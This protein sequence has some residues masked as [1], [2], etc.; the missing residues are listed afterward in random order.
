MSALS[1]QVPFPVFQDRDGQPLGNGYVWIGE[2]SLN[3]QTNPVNVYFDEALTIAAAQPLRT[4]NGYIYRSGSPAQVYVDGVDFSILVQD[5]K[6]SLVYSLASGTG[7]S[8]NASGI[9]YD[10][11]GTGAVPTTVQAKLREDVSVKD[12]GAVGDGTTD[13]TDAFTAAGSSASKIQVLVPPGAY[14]LNSSPAP[15]GDVTWLL[16]KGV[17]LS[18]SG[19]LPNAIISYGALTNNW[20]KDVASGIFT[21]LEDGSTLNVHGKPEL[22][23]IFAATRSSSG[24]GAS[25]NSNICIAAF[26]LNDK[27]TGAAGV[28][29]LY[30]TV[31]KEEDAPGSTLGMEIDVAHM[32]PT[33]PAFPYNL[34][35][36]GLSVGVWLASGG[37]TSNVGSPGVATAGIVLLQN[38]SQVTPTASFDKGIIFHAKAISGTDGVT[39]NGI[40]IAM[41][42]GHQINWY[43]PS[44]QVG[45]YVRSDTSLASKA[46][47]IAFTDSGFL[48][49]DLTSGLPSLQ[50]G[51]V[52]NQANR[53][54]VNPSA[55]G[56]PVQVNSDGV[57]SDIDLAFFPKG[58]GV[59][60]FGA[61]TS[62]ADAAITG[63]I[64]IKD[65][66][67]NVRKLATIA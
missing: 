43:T 49:N 18:G 36:V 24:D 15:T 1:I 45:A 14:L 25:S 50:I 26:A 7:I 48:V 35:P 27:T 44:D 42:K 52:V 64:T 59:L 21:Y 38:D 57:D 62:N 67:G 30:S 13:D 54:V 41:A 34:F 9:V 53:V 20:V 6:G 22:Q 11:A 33:S 61:F 23:G 31:L 4:L 47:G 37:E 12:F 40:A 56:Q 2:P 46:M 39:G 29:G 8:A 28:W 17:T 10:P 32:G 63:Y 3:A 55:T 66:A 58:T 16:D 5:S 19:R 65:A 51:S 60:R